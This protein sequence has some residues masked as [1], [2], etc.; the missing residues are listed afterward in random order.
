MHVT[1]LTI[2]LIVHYLPVPKCR[3]I[4]VD[5]AYKPVLGAFLSLPEEGSYCYFIP[6]AATLSDLSSS[7]EGSTNFVLPF[8]CETS[9]KERWAA[10]YSILCSPRRKIVHHVKLALLPILRNLHL[11]GFDT[12][13]IRNVC[14][15]RV[16][17][18]VFCSTVVLPSFPPSFS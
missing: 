1:S 13:K 10:F 6:L 8:A 16:G 15:P 14:D 18:Y 2:I 7:L 12:R 4:R 17:A 5:R 3:Y 9:L 11:H